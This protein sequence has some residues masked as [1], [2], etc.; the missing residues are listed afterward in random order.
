MRLWQKTTVHTLHYYIA[1]NMEKRER[2]ARQE[3]KMG[4]NRQRKG[5]GYKEGNGEGVA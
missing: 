3:R 5:G 1:G 4:N 2:A